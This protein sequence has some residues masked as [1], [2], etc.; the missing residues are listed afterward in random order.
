MK[1][2]TR[3]QKILAQGKFAVTC[4]YTPPRGTN[5][6]LIRKNATQLKGKVDAVNVNDNPTASVKMSSWALSKFL[7]DM[8]IESIFQMTTR[9]RNRIALQSDLL[10]ASALGIQNV[11][12]LTGDHQARGDHP[13]AKKVFDLDSI[14]WIAAVKEIRDQGCL[15]NGKKISG[16]P[17]FFIGAVANPFVESLELH[18]IS[19]QKKIAA[20]ADFIQTQPVLDMEL[21]KK[22]LS[23][24]TERGLT[25]QCDIIAGV[26]LLKSAKMA[27]YLQD[28]V[29]GIMVPDT[30]IDRLAA[31][32]EDKQQ[33]EGTNIALE[34]IEN[35]KQTKGVKGVHIM[36]IGCEERLAGIIERAGFLPRPE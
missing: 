31:V 32:S 1:A 19:L 17:K 29:S 18:V 10:G 2:E 23:L 26:I 24:A 5:L 11:L 35:L 3:L 27:R 34:I 7:L 4:E 22:W 15:M 30:I 33:E 28:N 8:S 16:S 21:F 20:G 12:C 6:D 36:A 9:D 25:D 14:Q 13:Q